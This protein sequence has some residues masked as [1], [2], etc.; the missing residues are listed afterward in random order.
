M[1]IFGS[2]TPWDEDWEG[3]VQPG[4]IRTALGEIGNVLQYANTG[5][6]IE[7]LAQQVWPQAK[8]NTDP[9][10][11]GYSKYKNPTLVKT[12]QYGPYGTPIMETKNVYDKQSIMNQRP[13]TKWFTNPIT[14]TET[15]YGPPV[16][17]SDT[18]RAEVNEAAMKRRK[19]LLDRRNF[20][21]RT[22]NMNMVKQIDA[23]LKNIQY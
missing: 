10:E 6:F 3:F 4:P 5:K 8:L 18:D 15:P 23:Q 7:L 22:G 2:S 19:Y 9:G 20:W 17:R 14:G 1:E 11:S 13:D 21:I 12:G 16:P